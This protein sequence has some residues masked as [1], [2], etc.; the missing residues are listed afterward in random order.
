MEEEHDN[1]QALTQTID[2]FIA[3]ARVSRVAKASNKIISNQQQVIEEAKGGRRGLRGLGG[4]G[5]RGSQGGRG[6]RTG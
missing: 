3:T 6:G 4:F 5:D 2:T 1:E